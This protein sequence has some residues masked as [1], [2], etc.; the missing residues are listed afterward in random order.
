MLGDL[1]VGRLD[2][3]T[4]DAKAQVFDA[5]ERTVMAIITKLDMV[6]DK[7]NAI[8]DAIGTATDAPSLYTALNTAS[9]KAELNKLRLTL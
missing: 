8:V 5:P 7:V 2:P 1:D 6:I 3:K 4:L 9:I